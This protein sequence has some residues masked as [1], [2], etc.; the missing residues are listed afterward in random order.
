MAITMIAGGMQSKPVVFHVTHWKAGSQWIR[1]VLGAAA[2]RRVEVP[3]HDFAGPVEPGRIYT[4][5][6][7][8]F[9]K[10]R[11]VVPEQLSQRTFAVIRD[12][13]DTAVS[14]YFSLRYS[15]RLDDPSVKESR[16]IL[17]RLSKVDGL[18]LVI[19]NH[20]RDAVSIQQSWLNAG[21]K[22]FRYEDLRLRAQESFAELFDYCELD[23]P[24]RLRR[25]IVDRHRFERRTWWRFGC[26]SI[27][28]HLRKA[29][30]GDWK[31]HFCE[32]LKRLFKIH[33]G[34]ILITAGYERDECW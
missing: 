30:P 27:R 19:C 12:P 11:A 22:I 8:S 2:P 34:Q 20:L 5:F 10:F 4:P 33:Y 26:Q 32:R 14:W 28:S 18:A 16:A 25:K 7:A 23:V 15:H 24:E 1:A 31:N 29:A 21:A 3:G 9:E 6:Y 13:R 17:S